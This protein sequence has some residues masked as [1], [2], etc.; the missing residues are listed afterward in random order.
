MSKAS[1]VSRRRACRGRRRGPGWPARGRRC[2][3]R[4]LRGGATQ[5]KKPNRSQSR[6]TAVKRATATEAC[7]AAAIN[8]ARTLPSVVAKRSI[9]K[10]AFG[11]LG[12]LG[13]R[14]RRGRP[15]GDRSCPAVRSSHAPPP[16]PAGERGR[17][18]QPCRLAVGHIDPRRVEFQL[19]DRAGFEVTARRRWP[20]VTFFPPAVTCTSTK[21]E[22][23]GSGGR[24]VSDR[25]AGLRRGLGLVKRL[26]R[27]RRLGARPAA[28][29]GAAGS[30]RASPASGRPAATSYCPGRPSSPNASSPLRSWP[31]SQRSSRGEIGQPQRPAPCPRPTGC[32]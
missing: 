19:A 29:I 17:G 11:L 26:Q 18:R 32:S 8:S 9:G 3:W 2:C 13:K 14:H 6:R 25:L 28:A 12:P 1:R 16:A 7:R 10:T 31:Q 5:P 15:A 20:T 24:P 21:Y 4:G 30:R 22:P 23:A 27:C